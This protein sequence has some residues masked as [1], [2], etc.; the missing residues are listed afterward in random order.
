MGLNV[1]RFKRIVSERYVLE[2]LDALIP[3]IRD[4]GW[5]EG[6]KPDAVVRPGSAEEVSE[7]IRAANEDRI[8]IT[9]RGAGSSYTGGALCYGG[10]L[11]LELT[12]LDG[13]I[14]LDG[15]S[16]SVTVQPGMS[17][18]K[19]NCKLKEMGF[20][21]GFRGPGSGI[22]A[23]IGGAAS[24]SSIWWG[25][26]KYGTV[27]DQIIGFQVVLPKGEIIRTGSG[28]NP[29][30]KNFCRYGLGP[31]LSGLFIGDHGVFGVKTEV[32]M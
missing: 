14:E 22:T 8:P 2:G 26:A 19:M 17:W 4:A 30:A 20:H 11:L 21:T 13:L 28:A 16:N 24:V 18:A 3:Y 6:D 27:G 10:G 25:A 12:R 23:T 9:I 7:I 32:V 15:E 31:D 5:W 1:E 29:Y